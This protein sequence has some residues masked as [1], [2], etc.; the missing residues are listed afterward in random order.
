MLQVDIEG[1]KVTHLATWVGVNR[2]SLFCNANYS[3]VT[4]GWTTNYWNGRRVRAALRPIRDLKTRPA[5]GT[6]ARK[7]AAIQR[8]VERP[9]RGTV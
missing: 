1:C 3:D 6:C 2:W 9:T 8:W 5:C 7:I 4:D